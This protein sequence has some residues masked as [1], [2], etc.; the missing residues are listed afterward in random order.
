MANYYGNT[1][2]NYFRVKNEKEFKE[3]IDLIQ[4]SE[5][6][7]EYWTEEKNGETYYAF[8][9]HDSIL[10]VCECPYCN[11]CEG[12]EFDKEER[13]EECSSCDCDGE[14][15][16]DKMCELLQTIVHPED[17]IIIV[18]SGYEKLRYVGANSTII[19]SKK[20]VHKDIWT[21]SI[22]TAK[23]MLNNKD[24]QTTCSY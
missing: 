2:T 17:A 24:Y 5:D 13:N 23:T 1:R 3:I 14:Y 7:I 18:E 9:V 20:I 6:E 21:D 12:C 22:N 15:D 11:S 10:G 16:Y 19:T 4:V 8:G